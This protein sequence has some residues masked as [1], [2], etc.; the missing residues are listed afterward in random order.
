MM[1]MKGGNKIQHDLRIKGLIQEYAEKGRRT[2]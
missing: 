2:F 1:Q